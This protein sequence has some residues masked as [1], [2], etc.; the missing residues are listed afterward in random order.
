MVGSLHDGSWNLVN[1]HN[2]HV[3]TSEA[4]DSEFRYASDGFRILLPAKEEQ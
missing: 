4:S 1:T 2:Y 3:V